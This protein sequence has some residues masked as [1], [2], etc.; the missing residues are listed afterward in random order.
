MSAPSY[1]LKADFCTTLGHLARTRVLELL[2]GCEPAV[3][4]MLPQVRPDMGRQRYKAGWDLGRPHG[5]STAA[6]PAGW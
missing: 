5:R 3:A 6:R 4:E 1:Q 2:A